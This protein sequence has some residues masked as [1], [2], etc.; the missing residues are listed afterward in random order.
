MSLPGLV[1][2]GADCMRQAKSFENSCGWPPFCSGVV[3]CEDWIFN[4][5]L[6]VFIPFSWLVDLVLLLV[7][8]QRFG[9]HV[10]S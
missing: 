6:S 4:S 3:A 10:F 1:V 8:H 9:G 2:L 7:L 5:E